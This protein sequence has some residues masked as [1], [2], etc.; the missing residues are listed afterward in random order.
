MRIRI[1][2]HAGD[3]AEAIR[4][5]HAA[6]HAFAAADAAWSA[7]LGKLFGRNAGDVRYT[8]AGKGEPGTELRALSDEFDRTRE[9]WE[10]SLVECPTEE[11][12]RAE[13]E[14]A[15]TFYGVSVPEVAA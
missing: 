6:Y 13:L 7:M 12:F 1:V 10:A 14:H 9:E 5:T 2:E 4:R 11:S 3:R 15:A 8:K